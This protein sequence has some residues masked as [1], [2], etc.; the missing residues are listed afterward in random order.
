MTMTS[1]AM[2]VPSGVKARRLAGFASSLAVRTF[3]SS[4]R[5]RVGAIGPAADCVT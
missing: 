3:C 2:Q 5:G 1:A 4:V